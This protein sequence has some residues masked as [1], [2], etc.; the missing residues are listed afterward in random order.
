MTD[1][2]LPHDLDS[3]KIILG[4]ILYRE[5]AYDRVEEWLKPETFYDYRHQLIYEAAVELIKRQDPVDIITVQ[6][7][8]D[9]KGHLE[10]AEGVLYI[11]QLADKFERIWDVDLEHHARILYQ[12]QKRCRL[13]AICSKLLQKAFDPSC[14]VYDLH[15][16]TK[17]D[18][19]DLLEMLWE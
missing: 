11:V 4:T 13:I 6:L 3:E 15:Q 19:L 18:M 12:K 2:E 10:E 16:Q 8:L 9:K 1:H 7:E 5:E 17:R 14:V